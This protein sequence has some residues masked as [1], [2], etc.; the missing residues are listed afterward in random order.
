MFELDEL[1]K[2]IRSY[3][4]MAA[5]GLCTED[6]AMQKIAHLIQAFYCKLRAR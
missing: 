5:E 2:N 3:V 6:E 4:I 1:L